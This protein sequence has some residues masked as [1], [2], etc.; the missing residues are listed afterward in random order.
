MKPVLQALVLADHVYTDMHSGKKVI[1]GTFNR[2][3]TR[4]FPSDLGRTVYAFIC[5][6]DVQGPVNLQLRYVDLETNQVLLENRPVE[7]KSENRLAS[8]EVIVQVPP[9]PMPHAGFYAFE[10][11]AGNDLLGALRLEVSKIEEEA[12]S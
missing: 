6:T 3:W 1:A 12:P 11:Y 10:L 9:F 5:L 8:T 7:V 4:K 2:L